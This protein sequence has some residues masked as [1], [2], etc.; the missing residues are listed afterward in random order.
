MLNKPFLTRK[1][2]LFTQVH[3]HRIPRTYF[4]KGEVL[5]LF[6][7]Y[8]IFPIILPPRM[9]DPYLEK[10]KDGLFENSSISWVQGENFER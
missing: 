9:T 1:T 5:F 6:K 10:A 2:Y 7:F 8:F 3:F 4:R